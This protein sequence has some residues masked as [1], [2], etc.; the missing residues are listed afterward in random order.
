MTVV[1]MSPDATTAA[2]V[3]VL[4]TLPFELA[5][6]GLLL[7]IISSFTYLVGLLAQGV[8]IDSEKDPLVNYLDWGADFCLELVFCTHSLRHDF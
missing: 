6:I 7:L 3:A 2:E 4:D 8:S 5:D 1:W